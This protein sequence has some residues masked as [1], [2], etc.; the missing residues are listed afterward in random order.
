MADSSSSDGAPLADSSLRIDALPLPGQAAR[1]ELQAP[2]RGPI[3]G[4]DGVV[5][6]AHQLAS[7]AGI[8]T[9]R[10]GGNAIDAAIAM[11]AVMAVV[12]PYSSHLGG[13]GFALIRTAAGETLALNAG[14]RAPAAATPERYPDG[15]PLRGA[16][17][18]AVP[19]LVDAWCALSGR[20]GAKPLAEVLAP[21]TTFA[22][23]GFAVPSALARLT[24]AMQDVL[25][26]DAGCREAFLQDGPPAPGSALR[27]PDLARTL[28]SIAAEGRDGFYGGETGRRIAACV[29]EGGGYLD[30][31]D[32]TTNQAVWG[33]PLTIT[34][35]GWTVYEQPLPSQGITTLMALSTMEGFHHGA[36]P[37]VSP[38]VVHE[39][40]EA[41]RL[42]LLDRQAY[43]GDPDVV[44][45]PVERLL[46]K[47]Y[48]AEQRGRIRQLAGAPVAAHGG[49]T[50]SFAV[51]DGEGN[52]VSFI[53]SVFQPWGAALL[54]PATGVLLNDRMRGFSLDPNSPNVLRP[55]RRT[56]HTLNTWLLERADGL[57][58]AG[59]TP[60]A[61]YQVQ[62]NTQL[63]SA[64]VDHKLNIQSA[65]DAP[66]WA[67]TG[68]GDLALES[69]FPDDSFAELAQRGH[70]IVRA[71][72]WDSVLCRCQIVGRAA[73]GGLLAASD[74][75][76][77]GAALG[78]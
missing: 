11:S 31:A 13:D 65:I 30:E 12:Q 46:S 16:A 37:V 56:V 7:S 57:I 49:D 53:Q 58:Y 15:T 47:A 54:A 33:E 61:D 36:E 32:L 25:A 39:S 64:I 27:Q 69:R 67:L 60:G 4:R 29:R 52:L 34:Y 24:A 78:W 28:E 3:A 6:S 71:L 63:V 43:L 8:D 68:P 70:N 44:N 66:K 76:S 2:A 51:A 26:A 59:G 62:V 73:N 23:E 77:D 19:G 38:G 40:A 21:A 50:T 5:A 42:A 75:R 45:V 17:S 18:V 22:R 41:M 9:L 14:G 20:L 72:P 10:G 48:A 74:P 55:G 35:N 1:P